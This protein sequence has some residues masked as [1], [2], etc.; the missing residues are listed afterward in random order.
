M[1]LTQQKKITEV[2]DRP[3]K[4]PKVKNREANNK[5]YKKR[6]YICVG[7]QQ[8]MS[9]IYIIKFLEEREK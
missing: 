7:Q 1:D 5:K 8:K 4:I 6:A 9:N 2:K 3:I